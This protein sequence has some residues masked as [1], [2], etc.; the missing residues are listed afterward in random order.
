MTHRKD[1]TVSLLVSL[2]MTV[3]MHIYTAGTKISFVYS[4]TIYY[5][6]YC[7]KTLEKCNY[8]L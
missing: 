2:A 1:E 3:K 4:E 5:K 8:F 6:K 7:I